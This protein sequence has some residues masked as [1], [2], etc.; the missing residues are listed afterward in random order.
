MGLRPTNDDK[1]AVGRW[2]KINSLDRAF[3]GAV[4]KRT[5]HGN[6]VPVG[7]PP[8]FAIRLKLVSWGE[9]QGR[10][11]GANGA[12]TSARSTL[13]RRFHADILFQFCS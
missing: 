1:D 13:R 2:W 3:N 4:P 6:C 7:H 10:D 9:L 8:G 12:G 5:D 11:L